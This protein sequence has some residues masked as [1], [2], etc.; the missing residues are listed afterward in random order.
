M[1]P[2]FSFF[3]VVGVAGTQVVQPLQW[4]N[5]LSPHAELLFTQ[6]SF[7][8]IP[9]LEHGHLGDVPDVLSTSQV[10]PPL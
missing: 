3:L 10:C 8:H 7:L 6:P 2:E 9:L 5:I 4:G 1:H